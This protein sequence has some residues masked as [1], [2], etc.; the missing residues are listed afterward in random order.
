MRWVGTWTTT[1]APVEGI[2]LSGQTIRL[3]AHVGL[4]GHRIRVRL[5]NAC[6][7]RKLAIGA[8]RVGLRDEG[9]SVQ[10]G[11]NR[12][13]TFNGQ[14]STTIP[15]GALAVSDPLD[16]D[17]PSLSDVAVSVFLPSEVGETFFVTGHGNAHQTN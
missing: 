16:L 17:V 11:S 1:P 9:A 4:G 6:G 2:A 10:A 8:V 13:V 7:L 3:I 15:A 12:P 14:P 5:S